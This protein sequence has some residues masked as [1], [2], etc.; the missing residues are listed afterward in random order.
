MV[1]GEGC[2]SKWVNAERGT[3]VASVLVEAVPPAEAWPEVWL[4]FDVDCVLDDD[5]EES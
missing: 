5:A 1:S 3:G 2:I 4:L